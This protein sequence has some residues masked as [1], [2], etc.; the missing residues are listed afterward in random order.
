MERQ[1][2]YLAIFSARLQ[3]DRSGD[4]ARVF[5]LTGD[6]NTLQVHQVKDGVNPLVVP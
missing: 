2:E 4:A 5:P 6:S 1:A 3:S